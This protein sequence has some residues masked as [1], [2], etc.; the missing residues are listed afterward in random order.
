MLLEPEDFLNL[1][2]NVISALPFDL[3]LLKNNLGKKFSCIALSAFR[4]FLI[5]LYLRYAAP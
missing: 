3:S 4:L 5:P 1:S 2:M